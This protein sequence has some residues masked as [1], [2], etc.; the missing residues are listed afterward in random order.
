M[1]RFWELVQH[2]PVRLVAAIQA[3]LATAVLFGLDLTEA[4][5]AGL[6]LCVSAWLAFV[7][8]RAVTPT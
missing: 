3:T 5:L 1:A 2:E 4:Q 6:V 8:R 7:T